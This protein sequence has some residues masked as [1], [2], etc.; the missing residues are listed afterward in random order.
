[1][2]QGTVYIRE[3]IEEKTIQEIEHILNALEGIERV[4]VDTDD[5]E[6]KIE[7]SEEI[8]NKQAIIDTLKTYGYT[9]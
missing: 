4:L 1:M 5:G 3:A 7:F 9:V 8:I 6:V 2:A